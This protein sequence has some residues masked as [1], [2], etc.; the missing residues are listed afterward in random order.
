[1]G[2]LKKL[3]GSESVDDLCAEAE[4]HFAAERYGQAKLVF[5]RAFE[6]AK[7]DAESARGD[8]AQRIEASRDGIAQGRIEQ[9]EDHIEARDLDLA[10]AELEGAI[11]VVID[12]TL[13]TR[14]EELLYGL[15]KADAVT[16]A[17]EVE[18]T[19]ADRLATIAGTWE[20]AQ[21]EEYAEYGDGLNDALL[22]LFSDEPK[23]ARPLLEAVLDE[24]E[25]PRFLWL[26]VGSARMIDE[27]D[28]PA[29]E[30]FRTFL[31]QL[32]DDEGGEGRFAA[33]RNLA[34]LLDNRGDVEGAIAELE[35]AAA[36]F[37][38]DPRPLLTLGVYL[39]DK[40]QA[41]ESVEV[42]RM[43]ADLMGDRPDWSI[44]EEL[45]LSLAKNGQVNEAIQVF[46]SS[47]EF[48]TSEKIT[49]FPVRTSMKLAELHEATGSLERA[50][51][52]YRVL[53]QGPDTQNHLVYHR[54]A[55]RVLGVLGLTDEARLMYERAAALVGDDTEA[56]MHIADAVAALDT[57][58]EEA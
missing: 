17:A 32:D 29:E 18:V 49:N 45:G 40:E 54:E 31:E 38:E 1:M 15:E 48:L 5:E 21:D 23:S 27:D 7:D 6:K 50:A 34:R 24:A 10:R 13:R 58:D 37:D 47:I 11:E 20:D 25:A 43:A 28:E 3:F 46:E 12:A 8:L 33:H 30:A 55:G 36:F 41:A 53:S 35:D 52:L 56:G 42:L 22:A 2:F 57:P 51:D 44:L 26:E 19:D 14:A 16:A 39:R 9:A 4:D